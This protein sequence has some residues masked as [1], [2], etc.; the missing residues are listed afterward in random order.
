MTDPAEVLKKIAAE[1]DELE[2]LESYRPNTALLRDAADEIERLQTEVKQLR[3]IIA[4]APLPTGEPIA[5]RA[6]PNP[7]KL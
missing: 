7:Y 6:F 3:S 1:I 5:A 2:T 4:S